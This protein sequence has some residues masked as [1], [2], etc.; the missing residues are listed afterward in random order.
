[1]DE[2]WDFKSLFNEKVKFV[3]IKGK[4]IGPKISTFKRKK[5]AK[6]EIKFSYSFYTKTL[7][8]YF[9]LFPVPGHKRREA[10]SLK[11]LTITTENKKEIQG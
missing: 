1:M 5:Y 10:T 9:L 7:F 11:R 8:T 3:S 6:K 2:I 4:E